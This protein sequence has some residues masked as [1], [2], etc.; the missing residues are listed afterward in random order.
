MISQVKVDLIKLLIKTY[1]YTFMYLS[2]F[3]QNLEWPPSD[4]RAL[5]DQLS[6]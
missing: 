3:F 6:D 4:I 5:T 2:V 1:S